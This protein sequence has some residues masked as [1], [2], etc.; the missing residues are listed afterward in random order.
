MKQIP[1]E[2]RCEA[3]EMRVNTL[4]IKIQDMKEQIHYFRYEMAKYFRKYNKLEDELREEAIE[5]ICSNIKYVVK[6]DINEAMSTSDYALELKEIID[7][8]FNSQMQ[9]LV[10]ETSPVLLRMESIEQTFLN[11]IQYFE[12]GGVRLGKTV[13]SPLGVVKEEIVE[14]D[15]KLRKK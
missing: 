6:N 9:N 2:A 5:N 15:V 10:K 4:E 1:T 14:L 3:L 7:K 8:W 11:F 13:I 12:K